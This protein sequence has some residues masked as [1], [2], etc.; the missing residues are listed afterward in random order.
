MVANIVAN[1]I[2]IF[3]DM[4]KRVCLIIEKNIKFVKIKMLCNKRQVLKILSG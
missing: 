1:D 3:P 4:K 2:K